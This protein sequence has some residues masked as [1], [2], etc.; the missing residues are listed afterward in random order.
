MIW[1]VVQ[2]NQGYEIIRCQRDRRRRSTASVDVVIVAMGN[3]KALEDSLEVLAHGG[4]LSVY[5]RMFPRDA[6]IALSPN[7]LHD[8]EIVLTGTISQSIEDFQQAAEM[9]GSGAIDMGPVISSTYPIES[10]QEAFEAAISM[11]TYRVVVN[12]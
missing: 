1:K 5:A 2:P 12:P 6:T 3:V 7:L 10:I 8:K 4:R 9:I 11:N